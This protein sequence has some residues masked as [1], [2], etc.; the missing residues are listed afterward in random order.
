MIDPQVKSLTVTPHPSPPAP[1]PASTPTATAKP[2][3]L[4]LFRNDLPNPQQTNPSRRP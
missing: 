3:H 4:N 1:Q 2:T